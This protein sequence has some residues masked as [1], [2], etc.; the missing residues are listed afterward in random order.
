M[1]RRSKRPVV[2][3]LRITA[4]SA[5]GMLVLLALVFLVSGSG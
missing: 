2:V 4:V 1:P 3:T 5:I